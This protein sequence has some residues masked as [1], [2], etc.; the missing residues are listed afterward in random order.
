MDLFSKI[1][2]D[3][4][5]FSAGGPGVD[6][7]SEFGVSVRLP[8]QKNNRKRKRKREREQGGEKRQKCGCVLIE[9][10]GTLKP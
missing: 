4:I 8:P 2:Y 10:R 7:P 9:P 6:C 3:I 5:M 1:Y